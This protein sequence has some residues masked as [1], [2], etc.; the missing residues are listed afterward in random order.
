[1]NDVFR[2]AIGQF[3]LVYLW[4]C[5]FYKRELEY[6]GHLVGN[7]G[8]KVDPKKV[9]A[10]QNWPVLQDVDQI[11]SFLGQAN[12]F[13]RFLQNFS[14]IVAPLTALTRNSS[15]CQWTQQCQKAFDEC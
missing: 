4:K 14:T 15:A 13:R 10:V 2:E 11:R 1:M 3:V 8:L 9:V 12:Y 6:L 5:N 7:D